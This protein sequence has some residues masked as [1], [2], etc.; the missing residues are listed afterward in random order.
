MVILNGAAWLSIRLKAR[1]LFMFLT[2]S[3]PKNPK[4]ACNTLTVTLNYLLDD[5][6]FDRVVFIKA[7]KNFKLLNNEA[8]FTMRTGCLKSYGLPCTYQI[9]AK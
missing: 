6:D 9:L 3:A 1:F 7:Y 2:I 5:T 8:V 4:K